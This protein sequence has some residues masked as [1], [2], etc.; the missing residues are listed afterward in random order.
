MGDYGRA[1]DLHRSIAGFTKDDVRSGRASGG[2][3]MSVLSRNALAASLAE[4]GAFAESLAHGEEGI[5]I[6]ETSDHPGSLARIYSGVGRLYLCQGD[7]PKAISML[8]RGWQFCQVAS[9]ALFSP[10]IAANLG[11]AYALSGRVA[12]AHAEL[13]TAIEPYRAMEMTFWLPQAEAALA[14]TVA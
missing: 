7:L 8:E 12:E 4:W 6:A 11:S 13:S 14:R 9:I 10:V 2:G 3:F 1:I 5:R